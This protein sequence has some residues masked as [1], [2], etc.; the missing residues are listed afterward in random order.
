MTL[1]HIV[2]PERLSKQEEKLENIV[3][4]YAV[5]MERGRQMVNEIIK[6]HT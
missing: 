3:R 5:N 1:E 4:D 6:T 2:L